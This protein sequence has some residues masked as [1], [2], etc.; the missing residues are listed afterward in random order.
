MPSVE[1]RFR[2]ADQEHT[3]PYPRVR[4]ALAVAIRHLYDGD[5]APL[6]VTYGACLLLDAAALARVYA[7]SRAERAADYWRRPPSL[8]AAARRELG[9]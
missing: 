5:A 9:V 2:K 1:Y 6:A 8:D 3:A 7:T 4:D